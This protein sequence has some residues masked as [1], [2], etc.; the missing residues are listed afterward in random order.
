MRGAAIEALIT[1]LAGLLQSGSPIRADRDSVI[2]G[3]AA[4]GILAPGLVREDFGCQ[5]LGFAPGLDFLAPV[6]IAIAGE[7][8]LAAGMPRALVDHCTD[9]MAVIAGIHAVED[10]F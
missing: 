3:G 10:H 7:G 8:E 9:R 5:A 6:K 1:D 2:V 4:R